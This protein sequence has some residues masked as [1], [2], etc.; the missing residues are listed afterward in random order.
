MR[1]HHVS[2][3]A[4]SGGKGESNLA[5]GRPPILLGYKSDA[6]SARLAYTARNGLHHALFSAAKHWNAQFSQCQTKRFRGLE[7]TRIRVAGANDP[8]GNKSAL[9]GAV[10]YCDRVR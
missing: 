9:P 4:D 7:A 1:D 10:K 6:E 3:P 5:I 8:D 2:R